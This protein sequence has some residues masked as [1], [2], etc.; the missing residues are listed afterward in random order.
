MSLHQ[1]HIHLHAEL[2]RQQAHIKIGTP[3]QSHQAFMEKMSPLLQPQNGP[4]QGK[5]IMEA[6]SPSKHGAGTHAS[7]VIAHVMGVKDTNKTKGSPVLESKLRTPT[8]RLTRAVRGNDSEKKADDDSTRRVGFMWIGHFKKL[9]KQCGVEDCHLMSL[10]KFF[11]DAGWL[12][13]YLVCIM[14]V[15]VYVCMCVCVC[16]VWRIAI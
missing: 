6:M 15:C 2:R 1:S 10:L 8:K 16:M 9:V 11:H 5:V 4:R 12:R 14:Y 3:A 13:C 7:E